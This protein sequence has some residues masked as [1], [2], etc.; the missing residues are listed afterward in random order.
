MTIFWVFIENKAA[1]IS[2][3]EGGLFVSMFSRKLKKDLEETNNKEGLE[4]I[5]NEKMLGD[6]QQMLMQGMLAG[7]K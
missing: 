6:L 4:N 1:A 7:N 5:K 3:E 2:E